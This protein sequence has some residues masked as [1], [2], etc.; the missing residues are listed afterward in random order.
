MTSRERAL[1]VL[2]IVGF[3]VPNA[4]VTLFV[5]E[6]G[7]DIGAYFSRWAESLPAAQ[8]ALSVNITFLAFTIWAAWEGRRIGMRTW[9]APIPAYLLVGVCFA[10]PLFL[11]LRERAI[12]KQPS[13]PGLSGKIESH[14]E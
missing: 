1:L 12:G 8:L 7:P 2:T 4:M 9:W 13:I 5:I 6:H 3:V 14:V 11:L 10:V